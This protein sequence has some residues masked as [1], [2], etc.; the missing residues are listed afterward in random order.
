MARSFVLEAGGSITLSATEALAGRLRERAE[1]FDMHPR[2]S[3]Q[4]RVDP[5]AR[6]HSCALQRYPGY[7][8]GLPASPRTKRA[9]FRHYA[10]AFGTIDWC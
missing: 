5:N 6:D 7:E 4:L 10:K 8:L 2:P 3:R 1:L 9:M